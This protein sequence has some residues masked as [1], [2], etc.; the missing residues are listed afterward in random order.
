M[1]FKNVAI[2]LDQFVNTLLGGY[3]DETI[4][5]V[6]YRRQN[7]K[8]FYILRYI[9]DYVLSPIKHNHC[10]EAYKSELQRKQLPNNYRK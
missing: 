10:Y 5:A 9:L 4:S 3:P 6:C 7:N 1:Y 8:F 2:G